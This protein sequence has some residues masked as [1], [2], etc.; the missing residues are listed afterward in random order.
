MGELMVCLLLVL[1]FYF[2]SRLI[3]KFRVKNKEMY[4]E[5]DFAILEYENG[6]KVKLVKNIETNIYEEINFL[7]HILAKLNR[8]LKIFYK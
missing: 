4:D 3:Y 5:N 2:I 7:K 8:I 1:V 6:E